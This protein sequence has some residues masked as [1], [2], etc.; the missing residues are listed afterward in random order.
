M[1]EM[2]MEL[3]HEIRNPLGSIELFAS[4]TDGEY[5]AKILRSVRLLNHTVSNILEFGSPIQPAPKEVDFYQLLDG[6]RDL[7]QPL[8]DRKGM[9]LT[10]SCD[11]SCIGTGDHE[12]LHRMLLNL[13]LNALRV[14]PEH[15]QILMSA[16]IR[17]GDVWMSVQ[18]TGPGIPEEILDRIFDP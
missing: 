1:G 6:V 12:L 15:G 8:A 5:A 9:R 10:V 14:T 13:A 17:G 11:S 7:L 18:D 16:G 4:M 2:A 3:A